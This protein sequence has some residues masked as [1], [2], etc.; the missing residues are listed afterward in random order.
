M[1]ACC[2]AQVGLVPSSGTGPQVNGATIGIAVA[3]VI[4]VVVGIVVAAIIAVV[5]FRSR[6]NRK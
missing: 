1:M 5:M 6:N 2:F 4:A 3:I